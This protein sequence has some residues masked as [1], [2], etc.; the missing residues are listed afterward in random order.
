[1]FR[2]FA[3]ANKALYKMKH[4]V[5]TTTVALG[6]T[7]K[8]MQQPEGKDQDW[9]MNESKTTLSP[10]QAPTPNYLPAEEGKGKASQS[11]TAT[12]G[13][14]GSAAPVIHPCSQAD[15]NRS[16]RTF[17]SGLQAVLGHTSLSLNSAQV[18]AAASQLKSMKLHPPTPDLN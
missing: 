13:S 14:G 17:L 16:W 1:M 18:Q 2:I 5:L 9:S 4:K 11:I 15:S 7:G 3:V 12:A 6:P 10:R 8:P